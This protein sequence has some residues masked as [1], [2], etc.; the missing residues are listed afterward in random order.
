MGNTKTRFDDSFINRIEILRKALKAKGFDTESILALNR[1]N[2][3]GYKTK[4]KLP[5]FTT[6]ESLAY[7]FNVNLNWLILGKGEIF[8]N[9]NSSEGVAHEG[10]CLDDNKE[11]EALRR[12]H[13][14]LKQEMFDTLKE[15]VLLYRRT[16]ELEKKINLAHCSLGNCATAR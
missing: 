6:L 4:G 11:I 5:S 13:D 10:L 1:A 8:C 2:R 12:Q 9:E 3:S 15:M 16:S 7:E 14:K